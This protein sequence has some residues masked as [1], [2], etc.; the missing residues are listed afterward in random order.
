MRAVR[1]VV[2]GIHDGR[3]VEFGDDALQAVPVLARIATGKIGAAG[4]ADE[5][6]VSGEDRS[7]KL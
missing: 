1:V 7:G 6:P 2:S 5:E 3:L 4:A